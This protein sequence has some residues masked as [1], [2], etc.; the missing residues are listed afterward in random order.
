MEGGTSLRIH[1]ICLVRRRWE[2]KCV[3][4]WGESR[5]RRGNQ[6][7]AQRT[8]DGVGRGAWQ[9]CSRFCQLFAR[10]LYFGVSNYAGLTLVT[11][12]VCINTYVKVGITLPSTR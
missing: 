4:M 6:E 7:I 1:L 2:E 5:M 10:Y 11:N 9:I 3:G 8:P 12:L